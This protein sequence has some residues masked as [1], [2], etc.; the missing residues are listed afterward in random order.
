MEY[1][2]EPVFGHRKYQDFGKKR[3]D[4]RAKQ[5]LRGAISSVQIHPEESISCLEDEGLRD[6]FAEH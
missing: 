5:S 2:N 1:N 6:P 4:D 3:G